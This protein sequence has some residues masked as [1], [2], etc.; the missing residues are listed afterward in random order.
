[1]RRDLAA[2][3]GPLLAFQHCMPPQ[4]Q[5]DKQLE[6]SLQRAGLEL[7]VHPELRF[8]LQIRQSPTVA[9][10]T[11][12]DHVLK[13]QAAAKTVKT[14]VRCKCGQAMMQWQLHSTAVVMAVQSQSTFSPQTCPQADPNSGSSG[15]YLGLE[16]LVLMRATS[17]FLHFSR[18]P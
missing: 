8:S 13:R 3:R 14:T 7:A 18:Y 2:P 5:A 6:V 15:H 4:K 9:W 1:M 11:R 16:L 12:H 17:S 10:R